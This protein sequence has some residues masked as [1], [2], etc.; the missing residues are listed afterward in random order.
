[1]AESW[2]FGYVYLGEYVNQ[3]TI[4]Y[5]VKYIS[6]EDKVHKDFRGKIFASKGIGNSKLDR[7]AK[8]NDKYKLP[9]GNEVAIPV[10]LRNK[11]FTEKEREKKWI[12]S[13]EKQ[14]RWVDGICYDISTQKG[15]NEFWNAILAAR[16]RAEIL[17]YEKPTKKKYK[18]SVEN[19]GNLNK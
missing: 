4:N 15:E 12:E 14:E 9:N 1:M 16:K 10:Y 3:K 7:Y 11:L 19:F 8:Q 13:L 6:K 5:I 17:G 18:N 2:K